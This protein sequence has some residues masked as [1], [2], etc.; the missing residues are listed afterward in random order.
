MS[1]AN[2]IKAQQILTTDDTP[3]NAAE[4]MT[5][6]DDREGYAELT[7]IARSG[8]DVKAFKFGAAVKR[9]SGGS[10]AIVGT[11][12]DLITAQ[13]DAGLAAAVAT[14]VASGNDIVAEVTGIAATNITWE[15]WLTMLYAP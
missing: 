9:P 6:P 10:A 4:G 2:D 1:I 15:T 13:G 11:V 5:L 7:V 12:Q 3:T 14:I 8:A